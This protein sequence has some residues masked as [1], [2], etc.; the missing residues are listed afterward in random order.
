MIIS[1]VNEKGGVGKSTLS[2]SVAFELARSFQKK[3]L[4][5]DA[6]PQ[7]SII[8]WTDAREGG[9]PENLEVIAL[10]KQTMHRDLQKIGKRYDAVVI[11]TPGQARE[12]TR[13][14]IISSNFVVIPCTPSQ[15]DIW[16]S[17]KAVNVVREESAFHENIKVGFVINRKIAN[18]TLS[19]E[20]V[21]AL[22]QMA[23]D[24]PVLNTHITQRIIFSKAVSSGMV[25]QEVDVDGKGTQEIKALTEEILERIS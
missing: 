8:D 19:A 25:I 15:Y 22:K 5:I 10:P 16:A 1:F 3:V 20:V 2:V 14:A 6:D 17:E 24:I 7:F 13:S 4:L 21:E 9:L 11:D 23:P 12:I 18:T